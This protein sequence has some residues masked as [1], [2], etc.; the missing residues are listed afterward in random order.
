MSTKVSVGRPRNPDT[1]AA[2]LRATQDLLI[3]HGFDGMTVEMVARAAGTGKAGLYRRWSSKTELVVAAVR[4]LHGPA[5]P[6]D[7]GSLREDLL[8]C[9]L[10]YARGDDRTAMIM[11][12]LLTAASRHPELRA[13]A[14]EAIGAPRVAMFR[15]VIARWTARG[16]VS[17]GIPVDVIASLLPSVALSR[18]V[19]SRELIDVAT[20]ETLVDAVLLP[21]LQTRL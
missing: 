9:A 4:G 13:A 10:H 7:T 1:D 11:A 8:E 20:V 21:A 6:P 18:V 17:A 14:R 19:M 2:I 12:G 5:E 3:E 16:V 15:T